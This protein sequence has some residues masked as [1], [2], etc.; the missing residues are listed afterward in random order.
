MP[1][2]WLTY[3][4]L[5]AAFG[6]GKESARTLVKRKRWARKMGNDGMARIGV[7]EDLIE[8]RIVPPSIPRSDPPSEPQ[9]DPQDAPRIVPPN[10]EPVVSVLTQHIERLEKEL[11]EVKSE[12]DTERATAAR[13]ALQAAKVD[14]LEMLIE[15]ERKRV[16]EVRN[17]ERKHSEDWKAATV[18]PL[19]GTIEALKSALEAEK[20]RSSE[21]SDNRDRWYTMATERRSWFPWRRRA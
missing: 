11:A 17:T 8:A 15:Q 18:D 10:I 21:L 12:R 9:D 7:P 3:E 16:E 1:E 6:I 20:R 14:V 4:E 19:K 2:R 5:A 13:L